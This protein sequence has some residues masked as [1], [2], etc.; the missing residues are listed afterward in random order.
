MT[1]LHESH[2]NMNLLTTRL[3]QV[4]D[5]LNTGESATIIVVS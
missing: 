5:D 4:G 3:K 2:G 1:D